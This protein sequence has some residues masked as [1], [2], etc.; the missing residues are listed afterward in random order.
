MVLSPKTTL[1]GP[2]LCGGWGDTAQTPI[3]QTINDRPCYLT[4]TISHMLMAA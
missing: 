3:A 2:T 4:S 1:D